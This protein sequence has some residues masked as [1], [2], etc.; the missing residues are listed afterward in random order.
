MKQ[1]NYRDR[2]TG[3][4][5]KHFAPLGDV[6]PTHTIRRHGETDLHVFTFEKEFAV[7]GGILCQVVRVFISPEGKIV[8]AISSR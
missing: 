2:A 4:V 6:E 3:Y 1:V 7:P 8:K 5:G